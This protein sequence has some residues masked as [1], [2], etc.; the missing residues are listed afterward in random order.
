MTNKTKTDIENIYII[1]GWKLRKANDDDTN[2]IED[3]RYYKVE[4]DDLVVYDYDKHN[5]RP[6]IKDLLNRSWVFIEIKLLKILIWICLVFV[7]FFVLLF[8]R[9]PSKAYLTDAIANS[10]PKTTTSTT[11]E[12]QMNVPTG[13]AM[14]IQD[15]LLKK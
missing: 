14:N 1:E 7:L 5:A 15:V 8:V 6:Y 11:Q 4:C 13:G 12:S 10:T 3:S 9:L 2:R